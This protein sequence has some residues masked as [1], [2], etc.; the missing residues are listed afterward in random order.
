MS[1][2]L[3][4]FSSVRRYHVLSMAYGVWCESQDFLIDGGGNGTA[5]GGLR[6]IDDEYRTM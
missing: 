3:L 1:D 4:L 2:I 5:E 6:T